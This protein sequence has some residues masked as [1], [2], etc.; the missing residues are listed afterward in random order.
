[1]YL[2]RILYASL[3]CF[4]F[5]VAAVSDVSSRLCRQQSEGPLC[6]L[7][8]S[9]LDFFPPSRRKKKFRCLCVYALWLLR[10]RSHLELCTPF[11]SC[12]CVCV[13]ACM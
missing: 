2:V 10:V 13:S 3:R 11:P 8:A 12:V 5:D 6:Y 4:F 9:A 1:M 7:K